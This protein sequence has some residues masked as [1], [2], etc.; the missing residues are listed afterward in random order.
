MD[1]VQVAQRIADDVLFPAALSTDAS[2]VIPRELLDVL[3]DAGLYGLVAPEES[4]GL[5]ADFGTVCAVQEALASG[6][7]TTAF[8]WTQ[9]IGLVR[10]LGA[11]GRPD[12]RARWLGPLARGEVRAGVALGGALPQPTLRAR[13]DGPGWL[14]EGV[15]PF[16][17]GWGR[18]DVLHAAARTPDNQIVWLLVDAVEG[19]SVRAERLRLAALNATATVRVTFDQLPVPAGRVTGQH[20]VSGG[21]APQVLRMHAALALGV[22]ARCCQLLGPTSLDSELGSLRTELGPGSLVVPDQIVDRTWGRDFT[23]YDTVGP[24]VHVGFADPYCPH[25]R[26]AVVE[27]AHAQSWA[28]HDGGTLV[29]IQGP[30]FSSRAESLHHSA[31]G[32]SVVGM[33]GHPEAVL[34]RELAL[35]YTS[36]AVVTDLDAGVEAGQGVSHQEVLAAFASSISRLRSLLSGVIGALPTERTCDCS[37]ALDGQPLPFALP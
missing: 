11:G 25:G 20:P 1:I 4:G 3:A 10:A 12:L 15:S 14:L 22:T 17:S 31:Q 18:I 23:Y 30:R 27:V 32:W 2:D 24:V 13:P 28:P 26:A 34:A 21:T 5:G 16:V 9:H 33:T 6:C 36:I 19:P 8:L 29:V 37:H 7:L 35:C